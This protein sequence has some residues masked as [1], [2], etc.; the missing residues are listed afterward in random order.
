VAF[1]SRSI[2]RPSWSPVQPCWAS[3]HSLSLWQ[4]GPAPIVRACVRQTT[5]AEVWL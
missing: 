5:E 4:G 1:P 2:G 3:F